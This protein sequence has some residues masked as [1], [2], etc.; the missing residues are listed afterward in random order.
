M[1]GLV[2][3]VRK[4]YFSWKIANEIIIHNIGHKITF[5]VII[6][7][8]PEA[9]CY[10]APSCLA[11]GRSRGAWSAARLVIGRPRGPDFQREGLVVAMN[12]RYGQRGVWSPALD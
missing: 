1:F 7:L 3:V 12:S 2:C 4:Q 11:A 8:F 9:H 5:D 6:T 10:P